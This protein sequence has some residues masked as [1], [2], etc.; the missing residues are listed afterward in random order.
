M[1]GLGSAALEL[2]EVARGTADVYLLNGLKAWDVAAAVLI[3]RE[4]GGVVQ[5]CLQEEF[6]VDGGECMA[7]YSADLVSQ[8]RAN[9]IEFKKL[10]K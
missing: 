4:A 6:K 8:L 10:Q 3:V 9:F 1:R 7:G 5:G 2:C